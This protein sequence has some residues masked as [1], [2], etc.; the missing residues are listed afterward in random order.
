[1]KPMAMTGHTWGFTS[2]TVSGMPVLFC[3]ILVR[4][5]IGASVHHDVRRD[6]VKRHDRQM[7]PVHDASDE[8]GRDKELSLLTSTGSAGPA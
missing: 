6:R 8:Q 7:T 3:L 5:L 2:R 1:M 4:T